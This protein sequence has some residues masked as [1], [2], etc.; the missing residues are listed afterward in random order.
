MHPHSKAIR[1]TEL[2]K[3]YDY[4]FSDGYAFD[5]H[6]HATWEINAILE[7]RITVTCESRVLSLHAGDVLLVEPDRF[8]RNRVPQDGFVHMVVLQFHTGSLPQGCGARLFRLTEAGAHVLEALR[9]EL[10]PHGAEHDPS[11]CTDALRLLAEAFL[12]ITAADEV[13][14]D[15]GQDSAAVIY[16]QAVEFM[17]AHLRQALRTEQIAR[18]CCVSITGLK[19]AF[20]RYAGKGPAHYF[21]EL[22][23]RE[24]KRLLRAGMPV[25]E[26]AQTLGYPSPSC[27]TQAFRA[28]QGSP[29]RAYALSFR[30]EEVTGVSPDRPA[31][32]PGS[33]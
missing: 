29:P 11:G 2:E 27:F 15:Y 20:R 5:G 17:E 3:L 22:R 21:Q 14:P 30:T 26:V 13:P 6:R 7:G 18:A 10:L 4:T 25:R 1:I 19:D 24:A 33:R 32:R 8:H 12:T 9:L 31:E 23:L 28:A 16:R